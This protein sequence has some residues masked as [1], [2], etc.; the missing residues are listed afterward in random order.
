LSERWRRY[1]RF[2][3]P[4]VDRDVDD[5][6]AYHIEKLSARFVAEG[7]SPDAARRAAH[8]AFGNVNH[9]RRRLRAHDRRALSRQRRRDML[10][11]LAQD[12]R[13]ALRRLRAE[14]RFSAS[15]ILVLALGI[16]ANTAIFSAIDAAF[17]KPLP[18][19][20]AGR[21]VSITDAALPFEL[22]TKKSYPAIEDYAADSS[23]FTEV[24]AYASG[25]LNLTGGAEP[26]RVKITYVTSRFF[27]AFGRQPIAGRQP[28]PE[29]FAKDGPPAVVISYA[30]WQREFGGKPI[31]GRSLELNGAGY[32][33]VGV[34]PADFGFPGHT[35]V[36]IPLALPFGFDIMPAFRNFVPASFVARLAASATVQRAAQDADVIRRR[37][38]TIRPPDAAV[39]KLVRPL[40]ATLVGDRRT[41]L[42]TLAASAALLLLIACANV[43]NLLLSRAA[44]RRRE[45]A[46]RAVLGATRLRIT[47]QLVVES[48]LLAGAGAAIAVVAAQF[49]VRALVV[50]VPPGLA[51][52]SPPGIDMRVLA[53]AMALALAT[54]VIF[55]VAPALAASRVDLSEAMKAAGAGGGGTR[56]RGAGA[57]G[58]L[59]VGEVSLA[60]MLLV[61]AGLMLESL[62]ALLR[63]DSGL[64]PE[65]V[66][67]GRLVFSDARYPS[68]GAK[69]AF[70]NRVLEGLRGTPGIA[71]AA[72]VSALPMEAAGGIALRVMPGDAPNDTTR[73]ASGAYLMATPGYF[74]AIGTALRGDDLPATGDTAH[75]VAVINQT[76]AHALWP[77]QDAIG[78]Q[79]A[80]GREHRVVIGVVGDI[81]TQRLDEA[82]DG[83]MYLPMAEQPQPYASIVARGPGEP[84]MMLSALRNAV[85]VADPMEPVYSLATMSDVIEKTV[86]PRR[87]NTI[88][89]TMF[90]G[91]AVLLAAVGVFAVLSYGVEQRRREIGVR[92][93][94][95]AQRADVVALIVREGITLTG[96]GAAIGAVAAFA[97]SRFVAS[98]LYEVS[99][100]DP[101]IFVG[102]IAVLAIVALGATLGP[103]MRA[104]AID[105]L[106]AIRDE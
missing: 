22:S 51:E 31:V 58:L 72:A 96:A 50:T 89:L 103:A 87:T 43:M 45:L 26:E 35:D 86:A 49:A 84:A 47:R 68:A 81:R 32:R 74:A 88:L 63:T 106:A 77:N 2:W 41:S 39:A 6:L 5:E 3:G 55:G 8:R 53:F 29:E 85:R 57:R 61:G 76:L 34:M 78:R 65:H 37:F 24:A 19:P 44:S 62:N 102:S 52:V 101:R 67:T 93:A 91:L 1:L 46:I 13:F 82:P 30:I 4:D 18:F 66:V 56:R 14:P 12:L 27:A 28:V 94:L 70:F 97:L 105:P 99:P 16:G 80:I 36:W 90:G 17:L 100:H 15:V 40:Q 64:H 48:L 104:T 10:Q 33:V 21:L 83:Q 9:V 98:I 71:A 42:L 38:R 54:S 25:G 92:V 60:V 73:A 7:L 11:D 79:L 23:V 95:G 59:V 69:T 20:A 75:R